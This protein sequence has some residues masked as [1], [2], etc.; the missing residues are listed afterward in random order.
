[1]NP[2]KKKRPA[3]I[4]KRT[5]DLLTCGTLLPVLLPVL[6]VISALIRLQSKGPAIY[7]QVR[8]GHNGKPFKLYKFRTMVDNADN[9][10][11]KYLADNPQM[12]KEWEET[13]KLHN[14]PRVTAFGQL[15]RKTSLDELPQIL[16]ILKG[17]MTLVG[18]R[19]IVDAEIKKY[20]RYY[21]EYCELYPGLTGLWQISGRSDTTYERRLACDHYYANNWTPGLDIK[22]VLK[23]IP[24]TLKGFGAY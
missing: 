13:H 20:G 9:L 11:D 17:E 3:R 10:L 23:T 21:G 14:D 2:V 22:I 4:L 7:T 6:F 12:A 16:N 18:P 24:V 5:F 1:M 19:P 15:L 8:L